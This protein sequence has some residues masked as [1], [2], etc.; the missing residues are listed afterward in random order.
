V[1]VSASVVSE[2]APLVGASPGDALRRLWTRAFQVR[3][4]ASRSE[5]WW[6][7][8]L[9]LTVVGV[10]QLLIPGL[11]TGRTPQPSLMLGPFGSLLFADIPLLTVAHTDPPSSPVAAGFLLFAGIW[12]LVTLVPGFTV[13]VRRLHDS[14]LSGWWVLLVLV[15]V[16]SFVLLLL[17]VRRSR[18][19]G[20]R[21]D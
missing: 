1:T 4:R 10:C 2:S 18:S 11:L 5:Y 16:G 21:F 8:L 14:N 17:A 3:G 6:W 13:A 9:N 19:A 12:M 20:A 15:P 7:M